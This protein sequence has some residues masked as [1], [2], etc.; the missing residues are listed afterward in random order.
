[1]NI[2]SRIL[3]NQDRDGMLRRSLER[4]IQLY[5]DKS[6]FV[7][8]LLQNAEDS[9]A[10]RIKFLQ[11]EDLLV[12]MHNGTAFTEANLQGLC[13]IG[14]SDK[15]NHLNQIGEFGV[16]FKSVFGICKTVRLYSNPSKEDLE[17]GSERF[18]V[19]IHDFTR[20][21]EIPY[22]EVPEGYTTV[23]EFPYCV[24]ETFSGFSTVFDLRR[25][26]ATR[27]KDL[28]ITTLLFMR[29]LAIIDFEVHCVGLENKGQY[30]LKKRA[31]NTWCSRIYAYEDEERKRGNT[32]S[33]LR[34]SMPIDAEMPSRTLDIAFQMEEDENGKTTFQPAKNPYISVYFPT[35]TESKLKF[36]VQ[37]PFRTTPNRSSVPAD[38][39]ENIKFARML[40]MLLHKSIL[41]VRKLGVL[42]LSFIQVLPLEEKLFSNYGLFKP[43]YEE[44]YSTLRNDD[45]LPAK[46]GGFVNVNRAI[47]AGNAALPDL[48][49]GHDMTMLQK[50][51]TDLAWLPA[52]LTEKG[53]YHDVYAYC[54]NILGVDVI[55]AAE[56]RVYFNENPA[57]LNDRSNDWLVK[58]YKMYEQIPSAFSFSGT[59]M[60]DAWIIR[61]ERNIILPAYKKI[62]RKYQPMV[63]LPSPQGHHHHGVEVVHPY[64][65]DRCRSF[66]ENVLHLKQPDDYELT[67]EKIASHYNVISSIDVQDHLKDTAR[68]IRYLKNPEREADMKSFLKKNFYIRVRARGNTLWNRPFDETLFFPEAMDGTR[69]EEYFEGLPGEKTNV[70]LDYG[71]YRT[72]GF[73]ME[74][75]KLFDVT[76]SLL[77][78]MDEVSGECKIGK[79]GQDTSWKTFGSFRWKLSIDQVEDALKYITNNPKA[80]SSIVKSR[81]IFKYLQENE[82]RLIGHVNMMD[83]SDLHDEPAYIIRILRKDIRNSLLSE[84]NGKW[85]FS[86]SMELVSQSQISKTELNESIYG[87]V[88]SDSNL[89]ELLGFKINRQDQMAE[90]TVEYDKIP[91]ETRQMYL[92]IELFRSFGLTVEQVRALKEN[93]LRPETGEIG[94]N[95]SDEYEFPVENVKNWEALKKHAAQILAYA[96]PVSYQNVIRSV[97]VSKSTD[98][99]RAYLM[100]MYRVNGSRKYACQICHHAFSAIEACQLENK[101]DLEL[102]PLNLCTCPNCAGKFRT[103]RNNDVA[104][105]SLMEKIMNQSEVSIK[106]NDHVSIQVENLDIWFTQTHMAEIKELLMLKKTTDRQ[107][108]EKEENEKECQPAY[109]PKLKLPAK[110][111][112]IERP[113][114]RPIQQPARQPVKQPSTLQPTQSSGNLVQTTSMVKAP[115]KPIWQ[116]TIRPVQP[117]TVDPCDAARMEAIR[118][119]ER[120]IAEQQKAAKEAREKEERILRQFRDYVGTT[121]YHRGFDAHIFVEK[122]TPKNIDIVF[123]DGPRKG[124]KASCQIKLC[125]ERNLI[126]TDM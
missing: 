87:K 118:R 122:C 45:V 119:M 36:I 49:T 48:F 52:S 73:S 25:A 4:I 16:G 104:I 65:Y 82:T 70:Y 37:G 15:I 8:E 13:D 21:E 12:V 2:A 68:A 50:R 77:T 115:A 39:A 91:K 83:A 60:L 38:D 31:L 92:E 62:D 47:I 43:L 22:K 125:V 17:K 107:I 7:Y 113:V 88:K 84:W 20:P 102:D 3:S 32:V 114:N 85:L 5:T 57:F 74:D 126:R 106:T 75:M 54:V 79:A 34:F 78:G 19:E 69:I 112:E 103:V 9:C 11:Y 67:K 30:R 100:N 28:G 56:L 44:T 55:K 97:R 95:G 111:Q 71:F 35:E 116:P 101:P 63:F 27:L 86:K 90:A 72:A 59:N 40:S 120:E 121:V 105:K 64:I 117:K 109:S 58:M 6:H 61:T 108:K 10:T 29:N 46:D 93:T 94:R 66:F 76:D 124:Q 23:F 41:A 53:A 42:D 98:D 1:M 33:F 123:V 14:Q 51:K 81:I 26:I 96:S 18:S 99:V 110:S 89:Y 80:Q 24:G